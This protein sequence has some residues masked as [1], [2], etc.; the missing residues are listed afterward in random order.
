MGWT[1]FRDYNPYETRT[2]IIK[3]EFTQ[4]ATPENPNAWGFEQTSERGAVIYA[5]MWRDSP[6]QPRAY[7]GVVFLTERKNGDFA[8]KD[9][10]EECGPHY[11][12]APLNMIDKLDRLA[13]NPPTYATGW[14]Q[15]VRDHHA[16]K[17]AK[18]KAKREARANLARFLSEHVQFIHVKA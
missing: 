4:A 12:D 11:Y 8:Y 17:N 7:F 2:A 9:I 10:G 16:R 13:P 14:R 6:N 15:S 18:A 5:I 3:R 1:S